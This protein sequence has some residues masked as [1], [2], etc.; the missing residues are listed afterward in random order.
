MNTFGTTKSAIGAACMLVWLAA[1]CAVEADPGV[2]GE[3]N[4]E[5]QQQVFAG[6]QSGRLVAEGGRCLDLPSGTIPGTPQIFDCDNGQN[7]QWTLLNNPNGY[8]TVHE[9]PLAGLSVRSDYPGQVSVVQLM[10]LPGQYW[11]M[12]SA[13][14]PSAT[15]WCLSASGGANQVIA[16]TCGRAGTNWTFNETSNPLQITLN[17]QTYCLEAGGVVNGS[18]LYYRPCI[19]GA[20]N[21]SWTIYAGGTI[22]QNNL[23][24]DIRGG[25]GQGHV[26]QVFTCNGGS[27]QSWRLQG[28]IQNVDSKQCLS[29]DA[30]DGVPNTNN[31]GPVVEAACNGASWQSWLHTW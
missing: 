20:S 1:G 31:H 25:G 7:Q 28:E 19:A 14:I 8:I 4:G 11:A 3:E 15:G 6:N 29:L 12:P 13:Q 18:T 30:P 27:N 21:Q 17:N 23:C 22:R 2:G 26:V 16:D 24:V 9:S 5:A 10:G